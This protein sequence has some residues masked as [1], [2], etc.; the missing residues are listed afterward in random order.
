MN[1]PLFAFYC[2]LFMLPGA[3][4]AEMA[5]VPRPLRRLAFAVFIMIAL[6]VFWSGALTTA[7][8]LGEALYE[9]PSGSFSTPSGIIELCKSIRKVADSQLPQ[10]IVLIVFVYLVLQTFCIPG[11]IALNAV[12][13][14]LVG[15][16]FGLPLC[17]L[18][19]TVGASSC[20]ILS[21]MFG[22]KLAD[23]VDK[24]LAGGTGVNKLRYQVNRNRS[25]LFVY[26]LFLRLTP[27]LPNWLINLASP[28][29]GV[30]LP[31][32]ALATFIGITPQ[33]YL[34]VRFGT[35][36]NA[37]SIKS[38]VSVWD[39]FGIALVGCAIVAVAKLK[40]RFGPAAAQQLPSTTSSEPHH[41][42]AIV[43]PRHKLPLSAQ[44]LTKEQQA[45][46]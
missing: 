28:V 24:K 13:G 5:H 16:G 46:L 39:T 38:I 34:S 44:S 21:S 27:I 1:L 7:A 43:V 22:T 26:L 3:Y 17:V 18:A 37:K 14:A 6:L 9:S 4:I 12:C 8:Q 45:L 36:A 15:V 41:S 29:V 33:T 19:G 11:T 35:L 40:K 42:S 25:E 2:V 30:P 10:V 32:F 23:W 31:M 20:Y